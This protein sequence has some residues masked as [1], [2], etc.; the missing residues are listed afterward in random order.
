MT[1]A[2]WLDIQIES[3]ASQ[4]LFACTIYG[5]SPHADITEAMDILA[6]VFAVAGRI[7]RPCALVRSGPAER[8]LLEEKAA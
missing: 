2:Q 1:M 5:H 3:F 7:G 6:E 4:V 8:Q